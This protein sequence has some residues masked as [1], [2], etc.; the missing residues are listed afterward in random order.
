MVH[1]KHWRSVLSVVLSIHPNFIST[2]VCL[3]AFFID[4]C[5]CSPLRI[6]PLSVWL[7]WWAI[8][9]T[10]LSKMLQIWCVLEMKKKQS[11]PQLISH[12]I[13]QFSDRI[14]GR[15][16]IVEFFFPN[17]NVTTSRTFMFPSN[18]IQVRLS[19]NELLDK[20]FS[21]QTLFSINSYVTCTQV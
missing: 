20:L 5:F 11:G 13:W 7:Y 1:M 9:L 12:F 10:C 15:C 17:G 16:F 4:P 3:H 21:T 18:F 19:M 2:A 8:G 14:L 6:Y